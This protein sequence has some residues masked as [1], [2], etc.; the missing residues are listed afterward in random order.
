MWLSKIK[1]E[2]VRPSGLQG[3]PCVAM[4]PCLLACVD[5]QSWHLM[6]WLSDVHV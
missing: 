6:P 3:P 4:I 1:Q 2:E 5:A